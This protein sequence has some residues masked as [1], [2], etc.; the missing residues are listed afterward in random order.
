ML[1]L[2][3]DDTNVKLLEEELAANPESAAPQL[4]VALAWQL[5]QRDRDRALDLAGAVEASANASANERGLRARIA[6]LRAEIHWESGEFRD[7][8]RAKAQALAGFEALED[9]LGLCDSAWLA[10]SIASKL[11]SPGDQQQCA[12]RVEHYAARAG[13][14]V[15]KAAFQARSVFFLAFADPLAARARCGD[16]AADAAVHP[17]V[18]AFSHGAS[19]VV[20]TLQGNPVA[21]ARAFLQSYEA[22]MACGYVSLASNSASNAAESFAGLSDIAGALEWSENSLRMA[23]RIAS[24]LRM[25][26]ALVMIADCL[27]QLERFAEARARLDEALQMMSRF[28]GTAIGWAVN[29]AGELALD[30]GNDGEAL[31]WFEKSEED[32]RQSAMVEYQ[33]TS[34]CK[35]ARVLRRM[36]FLDR[37]REKSRAALALADQHHNPVWQIDALRVIAETHEPGTLARQDG[38][39]AGEALACLE[40]ALALARG[41]EGFLAPPELFDQAARACAERG[42]HARAYALA[43][44][45]R[46][47]SARIHNKETTDR[48]SAMQVRFE[49]EQLKAEAERQHRLVVARQERID[50]LQN[51]NATLE[52]LG[53]IGRE[54]TANLRSEAILRALDQ[55]VHA[56]LDAFWFCI[57]RLH[58]DGE[59]VTPLLSVEDARAVPIGTHKLRP[60]GPGRRCIR[61]L[62]AVIEHSEPGAGKALPGT[63]ECLSELWSPLQV[64]GRVLGMMTIQS[65][66]RNAYGERE[67]AI[68]RNLCAYGAIAIANAETQAQMIQTEKLASLGQLV[69]S[70]AHEINTPIAA[71]KSR[72]QSMAQALAALRASEEGFCGLDAGVRASFLDLVNPGA[73]RVEVLGSRE[74][75]A[76]VHDLESRLAA[77][78]IDRPRGI[79]QVLVALGATTIDDNV[80]RVVRHPQHALLLDRARATASLAGGID[81]INTAVDRVGKIVH[82]LK[83]YSRRGDGEFA[84]ADP[85]EG[86]ETVL[87]IYHNQIRRGVELVRRYGEVP[88]IRCLPEELNQVWTNLIH[89]ALQAMPSGGTLTVSMDQVGDDVVVEI[90]DSGCGIPPEIQE[91]IFEP[92]FT[93]KPVGEGS[94]LGLDIVRKIVDKHGGRVDF[95]SA[96]GRGTTFRVHLPMDGVADVPLA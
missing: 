41:T 8:E 56:L 25:G 68:F 24:P 14:P 60:N 37:A 5:R 69:A 75:R 79:A 63:T 27:R 2:F 96:V 59:T 70:V 92:F 77:A 28:P 16:L 40:R 66:R 23:R 45:A 48:A 90:G 1:E 89:N 20:E 36:G 64:G 12:R 34:L 87:S 83:A 85:R 62:D 76:A 39:A 10:W 58:P 93:T 74:E 52:E 94:G 33:A 30:E 84:V 57:Y 95:E 7:A 6:L 31:R 29:V 9:D 65:P 51:A 82:A 81:G 61:E 44:E 72:G 86:L 38:A 13:D 46:Q 49:V 91:R 11:G 78:G 53:A 19:A 35:Q 88:R 71:I 32:A 18:A 47:A 3:A 17:V 54:I 80:L 67:L 42:D 55:H 26:H 21:A 4:R 43:V 15:R 50:A 22:A 73:A